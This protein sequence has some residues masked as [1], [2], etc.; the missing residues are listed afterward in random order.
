MDQIWNKTAYNKKNS[1]NF[2]MYRYLHNICIND[3]LG[4]N[5]DTSL[6]ISY[7]VVGNLKALRLIRV[8]NGYF[9]RHV[10]FR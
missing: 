6:N 7:S 2:I 10:D 5:L 9:V 4:C 3:N 8:K 1:N